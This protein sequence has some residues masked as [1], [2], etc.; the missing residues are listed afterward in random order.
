MHI[1]A[2]L[3]STCLAVCLLSASNA[4]A[5]VPEQHDYDWLTQGKP[6]GEMV[7]LV[8]PDGRRE[9][10]FEFNDRGRGPNQ[11]ETIAVD[12]QGLIRE[13]RLEGKA[14]MGSPVD[15]HFQRHP[16]GSATW[17]SPAESG[18]ADAAEQAYYVASDGT[19]EQG[20]VFARA[21]LRAPGQTLALLPNG[22]ASIRKLTDQTVE[23]DD[24]RKTVT[25]YA[26]SGE[27]FEPSYLWL[28]EQQ[29]LFAVAY[30]WM[31]L[32]PKGWQD[33]LPAL[34]ARQNEFQ[35]DH[36]RQLASELTHALPTEWCIG[37]VNL[38]DV[39][40]GRL[41]P[42][43]TVR[44]DDGHISDVG[45]NSHV[46][47]NGLTRLDGEGRTLMPGLWDMHAHVSIGEGLLNV[48]AGVVAVRDLAN[49]H[50]RLMAIRA[51][52][53]SGE[54][55]GT[56]IH[57]SGFIDQRSPFAAPTG[58]LAE[59]L[60]D[61]LAMIEWYAERDYP[62]IKIY[63]SITPDWVKP[64]AQAIHGHGMTLSGHIP[65]GMTAERAV[66]EGFDEIQHINMVFLN[67]LAGPKDDTRTPLRFRLVAEQAAALDLESDAVADFIALLRSRGT[68]IDP[69]VTIFDSMFRHRGGEVD[70]NYAMVADHLPPAVRRGFLSAEFDIPDDQAD[71]FAASADALLAMIAKL[72]R[73]GVPLVAG[74][75]AM[76]GFTLHRE[77]ELYA[78]A[79]IPAP[80]VLRIATQAG[81]RVVGVA[82]Q[83]GRIAPGYRAEMILVEG[84]PLTDLSALRRV[85]L[86]LR[87]NRYYRPSELHQAIGIKPFVAAD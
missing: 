27:A 37:S 35:A 50:D 64:M 71:T 18:R 14:Y 39:D 78:K 72:H 22:Q 68:V 6:S 58:R 40:A 25:L 86:T 13:L 44:V 83:M 65:S 7:T 62:H 15:E 30:G 63:S 11:H 4:W 76:A 42:N 16:D 77:L 54:V 85:H 81:P 23:L 55:I 69:T 5:G 60:D 32:A 2:H 67:F 3:T 29:E 43:M 28:D 74:T 12:E 73:A 24:Q 46:D 36:H 57:V 19:P 52:M 82:D 70:P 8:H 61:A 33:S 59:S 49:D 20:A 79:G 80:D 31:G 47:C 53:A 56:D 1:A 75:D 38:L 66:R 45:R 41:L 84:D 21:L 10:R 48:A 17:Q 87:G 51:Q 26:I 9:T 34:Q